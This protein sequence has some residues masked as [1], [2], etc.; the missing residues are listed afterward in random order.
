MN[1]DW[2]PPGPVAAACLNA[3][4]P[5][6]AIMG[7]FG[8]GKTGTLLFDVI[9]KAAQAP[10]SRLDGVRYWKHVTIRDTY[11]QLEVTTIPS[12]HRWVPKDVGEWTGDKPP[13]HRIRF[14]LPDR[15][16]VD[17]M[18]QFIGLGENRVED[19]M[20]GYEPNSGYINE[21]DRLSEDVLTYLRG[22]V[23]IR[24]PGALHARAE[25]YPWPQF[26]GFVTLDF[27]APD[28][29]SWLYKR[30]VE[31]RAEGHRLY[32]QPSGFSPAAEN[33]QNLSPTYYQ[34]M[35]RG[36]PAW[37]VR[38]FIENRWGYSREGQPVFPEFNDA[39]HVASQDLEPLPGVALTIGAD[40][41]LTPAAVIT[42]HLPDGRWL[43]LDE[44]ATG[45]MGAKALAEEL[46]QLLARRYPEHGA[47]WRASDR[48]VTGWGDPAGNTRAQTDEQTVFDVLRTSTPFP[49]WP[50]PSNALTPRLEVV[51]SALGR[52]VDG[53]PGLLLSPR[54]RVLRKAFN[55]GYRLR[56]VQVANEDRFTDKP[57]KNQ[58]S[59]PMDALQYALLGGGEYMAL[60]NRRRARPSDDPD[61]E[62][63]ASCA[64][65]DPF[66]ALRE[67]R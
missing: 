66:T 9:H 62:Q 47:A 34:D 56:R 22:R 2:T 38:R 58:W 36:Q 64:T 49:W 53:K 67:G 1:L 5:V 10:R 42:Q 59:H 28:D 20:R 17:L 48:A 46:L 25:D 23:G 3:T 18:H 57:E 6:R 24:Y 40:F 16:I 60:T 14:Q 26:G 51:R 35:A 37:W 61:G 29:D 44:I 39:L 11:R 52:L 32:V 13:T 7:P 45:S 19:V 43:I 33:L 12:W 30:F 54:C 65:Y 55:S 4:D 15:S 31:G 8:S 41:G 63:A 50:A 21:A 27:N